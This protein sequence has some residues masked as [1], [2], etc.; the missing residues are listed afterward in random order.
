MKLPIKDTDAREEEDVQS[1]LAKSR[2]TVL[3]LISQPFHRRLAVGLYST[4]IEPDSLTPKVLGMDTSEILTNQASRNA[5]SLQCHPPLDG[6][7]A[8][9]IADLTTIEISDVP[10][11]ELVRFVH[12]SALTGHFP[13]MRRHLEYWDRHTLERV[14]HLARF[15]C[16]N[17]QRHG[18][19]A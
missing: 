2:E 8:A 7:Q 11:D 3:M 1:D 9:A 6:R 15:C 18:L 16:R 4:V 12:A 19:L 14:A 5:E 10:E 13:E 17:R